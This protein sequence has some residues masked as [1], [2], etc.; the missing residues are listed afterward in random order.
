MPGALQ[1]TPD[2]WDAHGT[3]QDAQAEP[4]SVPTTPQGLSQTQQAPQQPEVR[5]RDLR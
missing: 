2:V 3:A 5:E 1:G 4:E